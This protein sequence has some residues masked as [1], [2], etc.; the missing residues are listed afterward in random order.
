M[1]LE[2]RLTIFSVAGR[3]SSSSTRRAACTVT[4]CSNAAYS[5][6]C[7]YQRAAQG[8][9]SATLRGRAASTWFS[10]RSAS[11]NSLQYVRFHCVVLRT[12][13][14]CAPLRGSTMIPVYETV[15]PRHWRADASRRVSTRM[16]SKTGRLSADANM[17]GSVT[18][19]SIRTRPPLSTPAVRAARN[20]IRLTRSQ[21]SAR[22]APT[23]ACKADFPGGRSRSK[24][25]NRRAD[26]ESCRKNSRP[27]QLN[28]YRCR[29]TAQ[30]RTLS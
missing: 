28:W 10:V 25:T 6:A 3:F 20:K 29:I 19:L 9:R 22:T 26:C 4:L 15:S 27:R 13:L 30:R 11:R 23:L 7:F 1:R 5:A 2:H 21:V 8:L 14:Q 18:V 17:W 12:R 24:R 16:P